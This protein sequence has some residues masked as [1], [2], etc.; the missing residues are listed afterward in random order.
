MD[1]Y[2][3]GYFVDTKKDREKIVMHKNLENQKIK[4]FQ[5]HDLIVFLFQIKLI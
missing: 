4:F 5:K 3:Y 1:L 2:D